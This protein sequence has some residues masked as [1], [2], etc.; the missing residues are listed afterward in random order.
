MIKAVEWKE[1]RVRILDQTKLPGEMAYIDC[2]KVE[3]VAQ[4]IRGLC[5]RGAPAIGIT[6]AYGMALAAQTSETPSSSLFQKEIEGA[7]ALLAAT[8]PTAINLFVAINRMKK[9]MENQRGQPISSQRRALLAE[10]NAILNED[11]DANR[12]IGRL[13]SALVAFGD[14]ILTY[15]NTGAL[16]TG[17]YGTALGIIR[18]AWEQEKRI[19]VY[20]CETRPVLQGARLT[21]WELHREKIPV[22]LI[23]DSMA[24]TTMRLGKIRRCIVGADRIATNGDVANKIGTYTIAVLAREHKIPFYV[25]APTSTIDLEMASGDQI[26]IEERDRSEVTEIGGK[27]FAP[28]GVAV[29]NLAFDIT[30]AE[31]ISA[32]ITEKGIFRPDQIQ[33]LKPGA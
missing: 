25:A 31:Y 12:T 8:R 5:V 27:T 30:P 17:G 29:S 15:C 13:G 7:G 3:Q 33:G 32:I 21:A 2:E 14:G 23:T 28:E 11:I 20:V 18:S 24:G 19:S 1:G 10:A 6:A 16:A 26:P 9:V 4:A 22:I